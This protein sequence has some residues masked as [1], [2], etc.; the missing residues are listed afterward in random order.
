MYCI[1]TYIYHKNQPNVVPWILGEYP[2]QKPTNQK[3][4][5][6]LAISYGIDTSQ[7]V[8]VAGF[9]GNPSTVGFTSHEAQ[10]VGPVG[11]AVAAVKSQVGPFCCPWVYGKIPRGWKHVNKKDTVDGRNSVP[12]GMCKT[13]FRC[14]DK[15]PI[16][17][18]RISSVN[19]II[20]SFLFEVFWHTKNIQL[21]CC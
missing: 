1:F 6:G 4:P 12:P 21:F 9:L 16:N 17:W 7:V 18:C 19:S 10:A 3:P 13:F 11:P 8:T 2:N 15:L 14:F 20:S 5:P